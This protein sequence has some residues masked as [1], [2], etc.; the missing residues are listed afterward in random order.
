MSF[1]FNFFFQHEGM[2]T[3]ILN[4]GYWTLDTR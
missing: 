4:P 3:G 2:E 1:M